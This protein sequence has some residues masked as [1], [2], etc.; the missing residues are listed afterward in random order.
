MV[1]DRV[2][3]IRQGIFG[4]AFLAGPAV[5]GVLL[6]VLDADHRPAARPSLRL[7][8]ADWLGYTMSAFAAGSIVG[9]VLYGVLAAGSV[10]VGVGGGLLSPIFLVFVTE[11]VAERVRGRVL[12]LVNALG[13]VTTPIGLSL[14]A[15]LLTRA[16]SRSA[17]G[18]CSWASW[19]WRR[20]P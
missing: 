7:G 3:A 14:L 13:L 16:R 2:V 17:P 1:L 5:A 11:R 15:L 4:V 9:S 20:T 8:Q 19:A 10:L 6:T 12:S 18:R